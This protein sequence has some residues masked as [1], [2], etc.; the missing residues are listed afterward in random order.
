MLNLMT[1]STR[2]SNWSE[3]SLVTKRN[4]TASTRE[5]LPKTDVLATIG[6]KN[7]RWSIALSHPGARNL[8]LDKIEGFS[9]LT[10]F[11]IPKKSIWKWRQSLSKIVSQSLRCLLET[12]NAPI[13]SC[14][15]MFIGIE[16]SFFV[17][18]QSREKLV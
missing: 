3:W 12:G 16:K 7:R 10:L 15:H 5:G 18:L 6:W 14:I 17:I 4:R 13:F 2:Q 11:Y 9:V 8:N 1:S